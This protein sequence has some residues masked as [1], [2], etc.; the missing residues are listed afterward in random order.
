MT[1]GRD[2][3]RTRAMVE[4]QFH[5]ASIVFGAVLVLGDR[6]VVGF[7]IGGGCG[8]HA[9]RFVCRRAG[10]RRGSCGVAVVVR[11]AV[12]RCQNGG[13]R[14]DGVRTGRGAVQFVRVC[15]VR[16][17]F[18][19]AF[20]LC[21]DIYMVLKRVRRMLQIKLTEFA[22]IAIAFAGLL[23]GRPHSGSLGCVWLKINT[24]AQQVQP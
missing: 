9:V 7:R 6:I 13:G 12:A 23:A 14:A 18:G 1:V 8:R 4:L 20:L 16:F 22:A 3:E 10:R 15:S 21:R 24:C 5:L 2:P 11:A 17:V 19:A